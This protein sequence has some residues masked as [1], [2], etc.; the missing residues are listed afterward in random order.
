MTRLIFHSTLCP[1]MS[2]VV[3]SSVTLCWLLSKEGEGLIE[4]FRVV[5]GYGIESR[6]CTKNM[7]IS[8]AHIE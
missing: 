3:M 1:E 6:K 2:A 8:A 5:K 7:Q 4:I